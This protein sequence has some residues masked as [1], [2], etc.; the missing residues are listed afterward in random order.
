MT[1]IIDSIPMEQI[2]V[3]RLEVWNQNV[4]YNVCSRIEPKFRSTIVWLI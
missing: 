4:E 1:G 3:Q 2:I